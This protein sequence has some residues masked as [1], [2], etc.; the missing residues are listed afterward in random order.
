MPWGQKNPSQHAWQSVVLAGISCE[1]R[2]STSL[3]RFI[4]GEVLAEAVAQDLMERDEALKQLKFHLGRAQDH[5]TKY[6]NAHKVSSKIKVGGWVNLKIWPHTETSMPTRLHP[7]LATR[8]YGPYQVVKLVEQLLFNYN[9]QHRPEFT[10]YLCVS[11]QIGNRRT[12]S[13]GRASHKIARAF[14]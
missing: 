5:M 7:K 1:F 4:L 14:H 10:W 12:F 9:C 6:A 11:T 13:R 3:A 8:Y 2:R